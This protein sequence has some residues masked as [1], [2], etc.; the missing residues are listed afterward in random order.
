MIRRDI[1]YLIGIIIW[2]LAIWLILPR[3]ETSQ[4][5]IAHFLN[6]KCS[7]IDSIIEKKTTYIEELLN[8]KK[9]LIYEYVTGKKEAPL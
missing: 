8:Y 9:S 7:F 6:D 3:Y 1:L 4:E 2:G 5:I